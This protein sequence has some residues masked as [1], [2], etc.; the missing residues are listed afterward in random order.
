M[1]R[2]TDQRTVPQIVRTVAA[3]LVELRQYRDLSQEA[4]AR[5]CDLHRISVLRIE[6][7]QY[8]PGLDTL[9]RIARA[10]GTRLR[11]EFEEP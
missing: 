4:L 2:R 5:K 1:P 10:L 11:V 9:D 6:R 3:R 8:A 7:G